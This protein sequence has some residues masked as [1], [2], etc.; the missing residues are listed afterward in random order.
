MEK[1][2]FKIF[3][4][5]SYLMVFL[6]V[7]VFLFNYRFSEHPELVVSNDCQCSENKNDPFNLGLK[8]A[9]G[10]FNGMCLDACSSR[11]I[12]ST[13]ISDPNDFL[14][15]KINLQNIFHDKKFWSLEVPLKEIESVDVVFLNFTW[16]INHVS[17][18]FHFK[19]NSILLLTSQ[20]DKTKVK[21][22]EN[23]ILISPDPSLPKDQ[24]FSLVDGLI[25][26]YSLIYKAYTAEEF[27]N[28]SAR[29]NHK[30]KYLKTKLN[31]E[32][33]AKLLIT[34][35]SRG[36]ETDYENY[37]LLY[38][39]CATTTIDLILESKQSNLKNNSVLRTLMDPLRGIPSNLNIG[40]KRSLQW[41]D[42]VLT[43]QLD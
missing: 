30:V 19:K 6:S 32:E 16:K 28:N 34:T 35:I 41:W 29:F 38:K 21:L 23:S 18:K 31:H 3:K 37:Q 26:S 10:R 11:P 40:T 22:K 25:G 33:A 36:S 7:V 42:L 43:S 8:F 24:V 27:F 2:I 5:L 17:L 12:S 13:L 14:E 39:N 9:S 4:Y 20:I 15:T 1:S